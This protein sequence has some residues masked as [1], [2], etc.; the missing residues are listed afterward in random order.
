MNIQTRGQISP[1]GVKFIPGGE[2]KNGSQA[3]PSTMVQ[4]ILLIAENYE[5][6]GCLIKQKTSLWSTCKD[7]E[8]MKKTPV[9]SMYVHPSQFGAMFAKNLLQ[10]INT[11]SIS[12]N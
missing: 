6:K 12:S 8:W 4:I 11:T 7:T 3:T 5:L 1:L 10:K 9:W 2:V